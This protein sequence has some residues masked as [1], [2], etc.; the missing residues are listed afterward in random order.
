MIKLEN[1]S[2]YYHNEGVVSLG[3]RKVNLEFEIGEF[4]AITGESG[5]G[6]STLLNVISGIDTYEEGEI[7][8]D[9]EE[10]SH[11]DEE[12]WELYRKNKVA[13]I[14]QNYNLIDSYTVLRNV[15]A[16]LLSQGYDMRERRRRA[17]EILERVGLGKHLRHRAS[18]LSGGE[19][20]RLSIARAIAKNSDIIV[21]DEPTGNLDSVSARQVFALL[22]EVAK[23]KLVLVVTHNFELAKDYATRVVRLFDGEVAEDREL[24]P[25]Q[26]ASP[27]EYP[28]QKLAEWKKSALL[29]LY[30]IFGQPRKSVLLFLVSLATVLFVFL[31]YGS[32]LS[33]EDN[34][35]GGYV[36]D[37]YNIYPERVLIIR[38]DGAPFSDEDYE[39]LRELP[40]VKR[41]VKE[42]PVLD[43][44]FYLRGQ[45]GSNVLNFGG[46]PGFLDD[47]D[48]KNLYG[49][50]PEKEDELLLCTYVNSADLK[51]LPDY[52][53]KDFEFWVYVNSYPGS[54]YRINQM[55]KIA[56]IYV[57]TEMR[58][59]VVLSEAGWTGLYE[60]V[61]ALGKRFHLVVEMNGMV[62]TETDIA[63]A[64]PDENLTGNQIASDWLDNYLDGFTVKWEDTV[65]EPVLFYGGKANFVTYMSPEL[66]EK[67]FPREYK[68]FTLELARASAADEVI[69]KLDREGYYAFNP[70]RLLHKQLLSIEEI[71]SKGVATVAIG[72]SL[73]VIYLLS[74]LVFRA[75]FNSKVHDY[76][77][78]RIIGFQN[79]NIRQVILAEML[80][81]FFFAYIVFVIIYLALKKK[82]PMMSVYE[83][84]D[85]LLV[86]LINLLLAVLITRRFIQYQKERS[87]FSALKVGGINHA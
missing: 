53:E 72:I 8:I 81:F 38:K 57:W 41:I 36:L 54:T 1:V 85:Y 80:S 27:R 15:E 56:G 75:I 61:R 28:P 26:P 46:Y 23:D 19:K 67:I 37:N 47:Y 4:V 73:L 70:Y 29:A 82:L 63:E 76:T 30:N 50:F 11:Y 45:A 65:L 21:A 12:D 17:K 14:F 84:K 86:G 22:N 87:L 16:A 71:I 58:D 24:K 60:K 10:T 33:L 32:L 62:F 5:S 20:Q 34:L 74:Y 25:H 51:K 6:K 2:K 83:W 68:Q 3:L 13:F 69:R 40:K 64:I 77:I 55:Y 42:D 44:N 66:Y 79:T 9:G 39:K 52:L 59:M 48:E 78:L 35:R 31:L 49:R 7:Y 18:K 43:L